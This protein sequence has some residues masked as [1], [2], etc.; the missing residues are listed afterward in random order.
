M[1][2]Q[3]KEINLNLQ[4]LGCDYADLFARMSRIF[5]A[6]DTANIFTSIVSKVKNN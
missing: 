1:F 4:V 5:L 6:L 2:M 3:S